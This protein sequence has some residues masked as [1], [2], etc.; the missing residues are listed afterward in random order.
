[1]AIY[2]KCGISKFDKKSEIISYT[3]SLIDENDKSESFSYLEFPKEKKAHDIAN[4]ILK[5]IHDNKGAILSDYGLK[6]RKNHI[7][8]KKSFLKA[9]KS[10]KIDLLSES[11]SFI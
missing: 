4:E 6:L 10:F 7:R 3:L 2:T 5:T 8:R 11:A 1:M 9:G